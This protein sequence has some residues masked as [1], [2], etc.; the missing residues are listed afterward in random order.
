[1][2]PSIS[3]RRTA[4]LFLV[5][6]LALLPVLQGC[7]VNPVTGQR[8][9]SLIS[10]SQ[11]IQLGGDADR[12]ITR[13]LGVVE[14]EVLQE[15]VSDIGLRMARQS[16]RPNL[17]W[18]VRV[19][20]DPIINAFALPGGYIYV[21]RG[22]LAHFNSEA[23]LAGVLGHEIGH[24]TAK[25]GVRQVS[26][27]Q[28]TQLGLGVGTV[29]F[30]ELEGLGQAAG[31]GLGLLFLSYGR[32]AEREADDL[33]L[34]YMTREGYDPEEMAATFNMLNQASGGDAGAIPSWLSTHPNP[35]ERRDRI[36]DRIQAGEVSGD[37]VER[38]RYLEHI[39]GLVWGTDPRQGYFRE[40]RFHH[41]ELAFR[42][43]MPSGW[44]TL[45]QRDAVRAVSSQEDALVTLTLSGES[46]ARG[47][48]DAFAAEQG[49]T[50]RSRRDVQI[51]GLQAVRLDFEASTG[52]GS[53][54]EGTAAFIEH[55][56]RVYQILGYAVQARWGERR[57]SVESAVTSF[58]PERDPA[59]LAAQPRRIEIVRTDRELTFEGFLSRYPS[60]VGSSTL[61]L[62]NRVEPGD[63]IP[64]GTLMK[65]V[66]GEAPP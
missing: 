41:P 59:V 44:S 64:A 65:R 21:T 30:P 11:E 23:E 1:M 46:S 36:R 63:V 33:G 40:A 32:D 10:E 3:G 16:E 24:V 9:F 5:L 38:E 8:E 12:D 20:D 60:T 48:S 58:Q 42:M 34:R 45:N 6:V 61:S 39:D 37:R 52:Q 62:L 49:V 26:R 18:T 35:L 51:G 7:A 55:D 43:D 47:A 2:K 15:Y 19:L 57:S 53:R 54:L 28:I 66:T 27:A 25:H 4:P 50:A 22:I 13:S 56:G 17:P 31:V 29:L 14:D